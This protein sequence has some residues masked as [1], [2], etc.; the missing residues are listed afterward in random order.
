MAF[1]LRR[2]NIPLGGRTRPALANNMSNLER[3]WELG[4]GWIMLT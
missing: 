4:G 3:G 2:D 1:L